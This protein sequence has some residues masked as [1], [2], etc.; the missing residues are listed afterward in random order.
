M[1]TEQKANV[2][3]VDKC[4][5]SADF[6]KVLSEENEMLQGSIS[7]VAG[8]L[9]EARCELDRLKKEK[10]NLK[11]QHKEDRA[12]ARMITGLV[13]EGQQ[14]HGSMTMAQQGGQ[15]I[16]VTPPP[17]GTPEADLGNGAEENEERKVKRHKRR[18]SKSGLPEGT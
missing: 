2:Q 12:A 3:L 13:A 16:Q 4:R 17:A 10:S 1:Q 6:C 8:K 14:A 7:K 15:V 11:R 9:R 5:E 18:S